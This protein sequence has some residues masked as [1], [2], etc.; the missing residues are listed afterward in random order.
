MQLPMF[1]ASVRPAGPA[2]FPADGL[3]AGFPVPSLFVA[4]TPS[5]GVGVPLTGDTGT[6]GTGA[7]GGA[8]PQGPGSMTPFLMVGMLLMLLL[9]FVMPRKEKK[10]R[11]AMISALAKHDEVQTIG[12]IIGSVVEVKSEHVILKVDESANTRMKFA[13][14]AIQSVRSSRGGGSNKAVAEEPVDSAN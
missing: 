5:S 7:P 14:S 8:A 3:S 11:E 10:R 9:L 12:G 13:K 2:T 6:P 1:D 4:T